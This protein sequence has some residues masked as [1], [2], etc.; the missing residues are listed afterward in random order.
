MAVCSCV[1]IGNFFFNCTE[2]V[3]APNSQRFKVIPTTLLQLC[4][5][6]PREGL[7]KLK[8]PRMAKS[9]FKKVKSLSSFLWSP[10][11]HVDCVS[12][13]SFL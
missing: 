10:K 2:Y 8:C 11:T 13:S 7:E 4:L 6:L 12:P 3:K 1:E 9:P 5:K